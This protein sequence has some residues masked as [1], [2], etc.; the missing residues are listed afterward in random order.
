[1]D[2]R[3]NVAP[4][5]T[6]FHVHFSVETQYFNISIIDSSISFFSNDDDCAGDSPYKQPKYRQK[7]TTTTDMLTPTKCDSESETS[8]GFDEDD[9]VIKKHSDNVAVS[10]VV[11]SLEVVY[12]V[13]T[14]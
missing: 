2:L 1:M 3:K 6:G 11:E 4:R 8:S 5:N 12:F 14:Q 7:L 9:D 10:S 13:I